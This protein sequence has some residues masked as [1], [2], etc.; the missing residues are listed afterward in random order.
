[1]ELTTKTTSTTTCTRKTPGSKGVGKNGYTCSDGASEYCG[2]DEYCYADREFVKGQSSVACRH[3]FQGSTLMTRA[4][5]DQATAW[6][7][8]AGQDSVAG[9]RR[10]FDSPNGDD[11]S[12]PGAFHAQCDAHERTFSVAQTEGNGEGN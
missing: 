1:M 3:P 5:Q 9:W 7:A 4:M 2:R 10:C 6:L 12:T 8:E 11:K